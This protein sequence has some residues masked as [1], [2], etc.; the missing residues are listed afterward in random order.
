MNYS[1]LHQRH[2]VKHGSNFGNICVFPREDSRGSG[3]PLM[4][5]TLAQHQED[6]YVVVI[7]KHNEGCLGGKLP[8]FC[9]VKHCTCYN[10]LL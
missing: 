8:T 2:N 6:R 9:E 7:G 10:L 1:Y 3:L 4:G 5:R